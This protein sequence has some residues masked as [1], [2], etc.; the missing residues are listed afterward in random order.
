MIVS[1][2]SG[3]ANKAFGL[4]TV[5]REKLQNSMEIAYAIL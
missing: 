2:S 3:I 1:P 4:L 5:R